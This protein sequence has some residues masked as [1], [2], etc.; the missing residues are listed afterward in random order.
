M[1]DSRLPATHSEF[2]FRTRVAYPLAIVFCSSVA[3]VLAGIVGIR[4][5]LHHQI[6]KELSEIR[7]SQHPVTLAE[8]NASYTAVPIREN[9]ALYFTEHFYTVKSGTNESRLPFVGRGS[10]PKPREPLDEKTKAL[11]GAY[12]AKNAKGLE[13]IHEALQLP[14]SRYPIDLEMGFSTLLPHL[15]KIREAESLLQLKTALDIENGNR[16]AALESLLDHLHLAH[17]LNNEP[18]MISQM[19]RL[20]AIQLAVGSAE[21]VVSI[22]QLS[23]DE[24]D[25]LAAAF[26]ETEESLADCWEHLVLDERTTGIALFKMPT[27][28]VMDLIDSDLSGP[29][30]IMVLGVR[31]LAGLWDADL[32]FYL[33]TLNQV[34]KLGQSTLENALIVSDRLNAEIERSNAAHAISRRLLPNF[35]NAITKLAEARGS[36]RAGRIALAVEKYRVKTGLLPKNLQSL[37]PEYIKAMPLDP[38]TEKPFR[39]IQNGAD[40]SIQSDLAKNHKPL[41]RTSKRPALNQT[42]T[43]AFTVDRRPK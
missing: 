20:A 8:A 17:T 43:L 2:G 14:K 27:H 1:T 38:A 23:N 29:V 15:S 5:W 35:G 28:E 42:E 22:A 33:K 41:M 7:K 34:E 19:V 18:V 36:L 32:L 26:T 24:I 25:A 16:A 21:R 4:A 12:L 30:F 39:Y 10:L 9:A 13:I 6:Q 37:I 31:R 40:Y 3:I 11:I